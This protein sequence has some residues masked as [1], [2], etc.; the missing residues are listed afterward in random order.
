MRQ[1]QRGK[2]LLSFNMLFENSLNRWSLKTGFQKVEKQTKTSALFFYLLN[3]ILV[4]FN[5]YI[6]II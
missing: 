3:P 6:Y 5:I 2:E 4:A 1:F